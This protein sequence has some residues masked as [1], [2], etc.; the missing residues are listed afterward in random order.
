MFALLAL[1]A[2]PAAAES[3]LA[4]GM[5]ETDPF[6]PLDEIPAELRL[7]PNAKFEI[8]P[9]GT[10]LLDGK[11]RFLVST[12][13]YG[14]PRTEW[15][16]KRTDGYPRSLDWLYEKA[17]DYEALQRVGFD[18]VGGEVPTTWLKKY[19]PRGFW[20]ADAA[21]DW[22]ASSRYYASGLPVFVDFTCARWSHGGLVYVEGKAPA[23][24]AFAD[25]H[26]MPYSIV[27]PEGRQ[28]YRE[29]W[30]SGAKALLEKGVRPY[31]Y[32]LFNEPHYDDRSPAAVAEFERRTGG[33]F[34]DGLARKVEWIKF[35]E[36][37]FA[38]A[39]EAGLEAIKEVDGRPDV[40]TA[41]QPLRMFGGYINAY[42]ANRT[43]GVVMSSTGGS[44]MFQAHCLKAVAD[45]KPIVDGET[46]LGKT[47]SSHRNM[48]LTQ[49][50]RG[51][52]ASYFFKWDRRT[53]DSLWNRPNGGLLLA[54]KFP[55]MALNPWAV[56][57]EALLG[58]MDAKREMF[59]VDDLFAPRDRGVAVKV[60]LLFSYPTW[61]LGLV[62]NHPAAR[63]I[64]FASEALDFAQIPHDVVFEEQLASGRLDR[65]GVL[66]AAGVEATGDGTLAKIEEW[67]K[68]GGRLIMVD[69]A[70]SLD[71]YANER[72]DAVSRFPGLKLSPAMSAQPEPVRI[73]GAG[74][75][76]AIVT[77]EVA[78]C[79]G[80][81]PRR[82]D[83][84]NAPVFSRSLGKGSVVYL[85]LG[86]SREDLGMLLSH[87]MADAGV[88]HPC[89]CLQL[90]KDVHEGDIEAIPSRRGDYTGYIVFNRSLAPKAFRLRPRGREQLY[91]VT[92]RKAMPRG[93]D[94]S[95]VLT[96]MPGDGAVLVGARTKELLA[97]RFG[98][99]KDAPS[100]GQAVADAKKWLL[101]AA[102]KKAPTGF[103]I[104]DE[105]ADFIDVSSCANAA[106]GAIDV[107]SG[108]ISHAPWG[109]VECGGAKFDFI[110]PDQNGGKDAILVSPRN[111]GG[112]AKIPVGRKVS[113][114]VFQHAGSGFGA[115]G[116]WLYK[117]IYADGT[118]I[119]RKIRPGLES[120]DWDTSKND[121]SEIPARPGWRNSEGRGFWL[122]RW[123]N[124]APDR[125]LAEIEVG[126]PWCEEGWVLVA[127]ITAE[128]P[129]AGGKEV[130]LSP[131][132]RKAYSWGG[133]EG[134]VK[135]EEIDVGISDKSRAWSG[136]HIAFPK[137]GVAVTN[138][139]ELV[140]E[141]NGMKDR[142]GKSDSGGQHFQVLV[143]YW[144]ADGERR[145]TRYVTPKIEGGEIDADG[146][147]WQTATVGLSLPSG[148]LTID[149]INFQ[150][151]EVPSHETGFRVQDLRVR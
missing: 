145:K 134:L 9:D 101:E 98:E 114:L 149:G 26:F 24:E 38:E 148:A 115:D 150:I 117:F 87:L 88:E 127:A 4:P 130:A 27:T 78:A 41:V 93:E 74:E 18:S 97:S 80:W 60:A 139:A 86:L 54:E 119:E 124:P 142:F 135:G 20:Q 103:A 122:W 104:A 40:R 92:A 19:R 8:A 63:M 116:R 108:P 33:R 55:Y 52:N 112:A 79:D 84:G 7:A 22:S 28:L 70:M 13:V 77:K 58:I 121:P 128:Q 62:A 32:E 95:A 35:R 91:C 113:S 25:G 143:S 129:A 107:G 133:L 17:P 65:Y 110:R 75:L 120:G 44:D 3:V 23:K 47:R 73:P 11:K 31:V 83:P 147:T 50:A 126:N 137:E 90:E 151:K 96:L 89:D 48:L 106:L 5:T 132:L 125:V 67:V 53:G 81:K 21:W 6:P 34:P 10:F 144:G 37:I 56:P 51:L 61:R 99:M 68:G 66:V 16:A 76:G 140:F 30:Q 138:A 29:M 109:V 118:R 82:L 69:E 123:R 2:V 64:P 36:D 39:C 94:G 14:C 15:L 43:T 12:I 45:G 100:F 57:A 72:P 59:A 136:T 111:R 49:F 46:Y 85:P 71:E 146:A 102:P 1:A 42:K 141:V 131:F 105:R